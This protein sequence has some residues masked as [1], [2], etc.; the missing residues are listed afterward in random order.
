MTIQ[1]IIAD[2]SNS[3]HMTDLIQLLDNYAR[4]PMGGGVSLKQS[5]KDHLATE[6]GKRPYAFSVLAYVKGSPAGFANCFEGFSTF[7]CQPLV[8]IHDLAVDIKYRGK[9]I[10]KLIL[11]KIEETA[12]AR[13]CC[14]LTLEVLQGNTVAQ[15]AYLKFGFAGY[16]LDPELG[17]A[18]FWEKQLDEA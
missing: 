17:K 13:G 15:K 18:L 9:G 3:D 10:A 8:N 11:E 2:Y 4:D 6:L 7:K 12:K 16:E 1:C 14:K 5:A